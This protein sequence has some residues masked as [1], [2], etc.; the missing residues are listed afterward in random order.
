M[1]GT[2]KFGFNTMYILKESSNWRI[3]THENFDE[4]Y[5]HVKKGLT[6]FQIGT[7]YRMTIIDQKILLKFEK[8]GKKVIYISES[9]YRMLSGSKTTFII[10]GYLKE[11]A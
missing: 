8:L 1:V 10:Q 2:V 6:E 5:E 7:A 3:V 9:G 4:A 11:V